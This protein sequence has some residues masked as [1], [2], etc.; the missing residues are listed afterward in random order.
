ML[1]KM[2]HANLPDTV[3]QN[4]GAFY[5]DQA[6][7][8]KKDQKLDVALTLYNQAKETLTSL[9]SVKEALRNAQ[10]PKVCAD[11]TLRSLLADA[12]F[13]RGEVL[14]SLNLPEKAQASYLKA[15]KWG[16]TKTPSHKFA[17]GQN[18]RLDPSGKGQ[19]NAPSS[20]ISE[21]RHLNG[22]SSSRVSQPSKATNQPLQFFLT[23]PIVPVAE[24]PVFKIG[25]SLLST[26]HLAY[27]LNT[28]LQSTQEQSHLKTSNEAQEIAEEI[29][30]LY[31]LADETVTA[32]MNDKSKNASVVAEIVL[33]APILK[34]GS[35]R[36]LLGHFI[37]EIRNATF[38]E[39]DL[40]NGLPEVIR[41]A[42]PEY[43]LEDELVKILE[44]LSKRLQ[45]T[46]K[47]SIPNIS[48]LTCAV[49]RM[50][51]AMADSKVVGLD[52]EILHAPLLSYLKGLQSHSDP[53]LVY[54]AA[55]ACEALKCVPDDE[56]PWQAGLRRANAMLKG[57]S[58]LISAVK[59]FDLNKFLEGFTD[60][61]SGFEGTAELLKTLS[62]AY[63]QVT[64]LIESGE[65]FAVSLK[66]GLAWNLR[67][68]W[69][70]VLRG[71]D[72]L[73]QQKSLTGVEK[74]VMG[75]KVS[76]L[77]NRAFQWG[78]SERLGQLA[79]D[80]NWESEARQSALRFL[81]DLYTNDKR[82]G[83]Q[84]VVKQ[85]IIQI[86]REL[87]QTAS[88]IVGAAKKLLGEFSQTR[89]AE[90]R[91]LFQNFD[92]EAA[93]SPY[94]LFMEPPQPILPSMLD[95]VQRKPE[96]ELSL[97]RLQKKRLAAW[98]R[99]KTL[100]ISLRGK[101][102]RFTTETFKL[103]PAVNVFL[104][105]EKQKVL[106]LLGDSGAG[107]STF[108]KALEAQLWEAYQKDGRIPLLITLPDIDNPTHQ[109]VE[110]HL[111]NEQFSEQQ[112]R[113][114]KENHQFV[115][116]LDS[117]DESQQTQN[118]YQAN[119]FNQDGQWQGQ[120][121]IGCR[122]EYF[123]HDDRDRFE[124]E[125]PK[126]LQEMVIAPFSNEEIDAYLSTY[127]KAN[128][129]GWSVARYQEA[130][131]TISNLKELVSNPF[132][133]KI[134]L[135]V[136]PTLVNHL[137][138]NPLTGTALYD[139]FVE[140]WFERA[141]QRFLKERKLEGQDKKVF[142]EL[143][144]EG[145]TR[146]GIAFVKSLAIQIYERQGGNPIVRY[147]RFED[148]ETW[149]EEFFG[150]G[151]EQRLLREAW[152][153]SRNGDQYQFIHKSLLEYFVAR[154]VFGPEDTMIS[155]EKMDEPKPILSRRSSVSSIFSVDTEI[156]ASETEKA[157]TPLSNSLLARKNLVKEPAIL[158]FLVERAQK[159]PAFRNQ[160]YILIEQSKMES[161]FWKAAVVSNQQ[162]ATQA[163]KKAAANAITILVKAGV[164]FN[165]ADL[166]GIQV[167]RADLSFGVFD[168]AQ[169][170]G[171]DLRGV[172]LR[173]I[174]LREANLSNA[175]MSR[176]QFGEWP[177]LNVGGFVRS[178][179]YSPDGK[180]C[181]VGLGDGKIKVYSTSNWAE[182]C[183]FQ[184]HKT[185]VNGVVY[186]PNGAHI[187]SVSDDATVQLWD[188]ESGGF[189]YTL[190]GHKYRVTSV[191]YSPNGEQ[192]AS[193]SQDATVRLWDVRKGTP[194]YILEGHANRV[195]SVAY[196]PSGEQ[197]A[198]GSHDNT[199]RLWDAHSGTVLH[200]L[201]RH[202]DFVTSVAYSPSGE[203][204]AS[205][206]YDGTVQLWDV[207]GGT[208]GYTLREHLARVN[209]VV[210]SPNGEQI[211]SGSDDQTVRVWD[212]CSGASA[213]TLAGHVESIR[214]V[215]YSPNGKQIASGS[216]DGTVR[217]WS[218]PI[219]AFENTLGGHKNFV[220]S[221]A[222][223]LSGEQIA[224]GSWDGT[225]RLWDA[226]NGV[227]GSVALAY[228]INSVAYSPN[229][230]QIALVGQNSMVHLWNVRSG[231]SECVSE[232]HAAAVYSV[233]YSPSGEHIAS[234]S[235]DQTVRLWN[236]EGG[237]L[238]HTLK[239]HTSVV[240][241]VAYS[242]SG[243]QIASG[244]R[245]KTVR[246]WDAYS[247]AAGHTLE[248]HTDI[249]GSVT[250]S[251]SGEQLASSSSDKTVRLW[252][253]HSGLAGHILQGHTLNVSSVTYSPS[254]EQLA[255]GSW[256][257]TVRLWGVTSGECLTVIQNF[258]AS[259]IDSAINSVACKIAPGG[260]YL[261]AGGNDKLVRQWQVTATEA[262][263]QARLHWISSHA[264]LTM[265][266]CLVDGV[267]NLNEVNKA[268]LKQRVAVNSPL[269]NATLISSGL[270]AKF[271]ERGPDV[272]TQPS[273]C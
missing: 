34:E 56:T 172:N 85:R 4:L 160:L 81:G 32:F 28:L 22:I 147:V 125:D 261:L 153:L 250:Y 166:R 97:R 116:I 137:S 216:Y 60:I 221:V 61:Q 39:F 193:G 18:T 142:E 184:G 190:E 59:G 6:R 242:P 101:A 264:G 118:L 265:T 58:S 123:G 243:T 180:N 239:G 130:L 262:G 188:A 237:A 80:P 20:T 47:S 175:Q 146:N 14:E 212:A 78:L 131:Q 164:Q 186:S 129:L 224:S 273:H 17:S 11:E 65:N 75:Q 214:S 192:I 50:L 228:H 222:Y 63:E 139:R 73:V 29:E 178:C 247:G 110:R 45:E 91:A 42:A 109:L 72:V 225:V 95:S 211:A 37:D 19:P 176:V 152:P 161:E 256:D 46:F 207:H 148:R 96:V 174:W 229:G 200:I 220:S 79:A 67:G 144:D 2:F 90:K 122:T 236:A 167:P 9:R 254:G 8:Q 24:E 84:V 270:P 53:Y 198:S 10:N 246:L 140:Y 94:S 255:S 132:L 120:V 266:N 218:A 27:C 76:C 240:E 197:I 209:S 145:F 154:A 201:Q 100:Y 52:R 157:T 70:E 231:T 219:N 106:L 5:I 136:L 138:G 108:S 16:H 1:E 183:T 199:V 177:H 253:T 12:Y 191:V 30:R 272:S 202:T 203:Q 151:D 268:L 54:Q 165:G 251:P 57:T 269:S 88:P 25:E 121:I 141:K 15:E 113:E 158:R 93:T 227:P 111:S 87:A 104:E 31:R 210:Y 127:V 21:I 115:F 51:D 271:T 83:K 40:L 258:S 245:D 257:G 55:Y 185:K 107:K 103:E 182:I 64:S 217:L 215:V 163:I 26:Q 66:D 44:I 249:V 134:T 194:G 205:G 117:Y 187:A 179:A 99:D 155:S 112:I 150:S 195:S 263:Y 162:V 234:G 267:K 260:F 171:A 124:P 35:F 49:S 223:S 114:L 149:K 226:K 102:N 128:S 230:K 156:D 98:Q 62:E 7:A 238:R 204:M 13:E 69:Y 82:W 89:D 77:Q 181:A 41:G 244:S 43:A 48:R 170:Q 143:I 33:L 208:A 159:E 23:D 213:R 233:T 259:A 135:E 235:A 133:L 36:R 71:V 126:Q 105:S 232:E 196:S 189:L 173:N 74:L 169:L 92:K 206:S 241:S 248:G 119:R 168:S 252:D 38:L 68:V 86:I 3:T